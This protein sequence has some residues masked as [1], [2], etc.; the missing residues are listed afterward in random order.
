MKHKVLYLA[1]L[2]LGGVLASVV[3]YQNSP[4]ARAV[5]VPAGTKL[6]IR[7]NQTLDTSRNHAGDRFSAR[8]ETPIVMDGEVVLPRGT[9][10]QGHIAAAKPSGRLKGRGY[11]TITLDSFQLNGQSY[12][13]LP[14]SQ[15]R[16]TAS[17]KDRNLKWIVGG[18]SGGAVIGAL[19]GGAKGALI[20]GPVGVAAGV[21]GAA[22]TGTE[23]VSFPAETVLTF[24][25]RQPVR[26]EN[27]E[28]NVS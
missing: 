3:A 18:G 2:L 25:L 17:H 16:T 20:G 14:T 15:S 23:H 6:K 4:S 9:A 27:A 19:T 1:P 7:L 21:A 13:V 5:E 28:R 24:S 26:I 11:M 12:R 8:L 22:L 10:F